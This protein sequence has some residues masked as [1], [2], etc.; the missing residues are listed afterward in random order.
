MKY[1]RYFLVVIFGLTLIEIS[2]LP[3]YAED[4]PCLECHIKLKEP[5]KNV[6]A[7]MKTGCETCHRRDEAKKHPGDNKSIVLTQNM[8]KLCYTCHDEAKFRGNVVHAPFAS[9]MCTSCH[10]PHQSNNS[11]ILR[12]PSPEVCYTCHDKAKFT[13][14]YV[15]NVINVVGCGTCH[16]PHASPYQ[17]LLPSSS[18]DICITCHKGQST[19]GHVISIPGG[20]FHPVRGVTD[21]STITW[22]KVPDPKNPKHLIEIPD[23][24]KPGKELGCTSCHDPHSSD[25]KRLFPIQRVCRKCHKEY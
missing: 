21:T 23:P 19:G 1:F 16:S 10:D 18:T 8:P 24:E 2:S 13:K 17:Y 5:A 20:R 6:H 12:E 4:S 3:V 22:I 25:Y 11:K 7:A 9:G 14:K 15:H